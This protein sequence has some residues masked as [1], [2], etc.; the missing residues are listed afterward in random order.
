MNARWLENKIIEMAEDIKDLKELL[1]AA[2]K[3]PT[4]KK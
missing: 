2:A 1:K 3:S 4:K